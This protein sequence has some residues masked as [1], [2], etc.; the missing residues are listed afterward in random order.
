MTTLA[1]IRV[2]IKKLDDELQT[3]KKE[4]QRVSADIAKTK[5]LGNKKE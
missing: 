5:P 3:I 4:F 1:K 2:K